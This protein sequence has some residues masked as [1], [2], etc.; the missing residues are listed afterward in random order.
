[1]KSPLQYCKVISLQLIKINGKKKVELKTTGTRACT[2][3]VVQTVKN[4]PVMQEAQVRSL[5]GD[6]PPGEGN[7]YPLKY[8]CLENP[9]DTDGTGG[10]QSMASQRVRHD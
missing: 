6:D 5:D 9:M 2:S 10:L 1:M 3:L 7:G 4:P 8:S